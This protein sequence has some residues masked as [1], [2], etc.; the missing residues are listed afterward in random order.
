M[1]FTFDFIYIK[2]YC[3]ISSH[4]FELGR[5]KIQIKQN[6][7]FSKIESK[8]MDKKEKIT[9]KKMLDLKLRQEH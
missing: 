9:K 8:K 3:L 2:W 7:R 6:L 5:K 1:N 4:Q